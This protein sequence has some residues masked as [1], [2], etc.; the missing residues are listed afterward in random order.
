M[1]HTKLTGAGPTAIGGGSWGL[2]KKPRKGAVDGRKRYSE[3]AGSLSDF[4]FGGGCGEGR[5][6]TAIA[7]AA[8]GF[9]ASLNMRS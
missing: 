2:Q 6:V 8:L 3:N 9:F 4:F 7:L 1:H 5:V